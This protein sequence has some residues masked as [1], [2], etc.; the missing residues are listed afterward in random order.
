M[1]DQRSCARVCHRAEDAVLIDDITWAPLQ[2]VGCNPSGLV[3]N[4]EGC[5]VYSRATDRHG[6]RVERAGPEWYRLRVSL[7]HVDVVK[8]NSKHTGRNLGETGGMTLA[9]A[10][11]AA[12]RGRPPVAMADHAGAFVAGSPEANCTQCH[13][14][15]GTGALRKSRE[16]DTEMTAL[17]AQTRLLRAQL[18]IACQL[19]GCVHVGGVIARIKRQPGR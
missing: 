1:R 17:S 15:S 5:L 10:L 9:S 11:R 14:R 19:Q 3:H 6:S 7:H 12:E 8:H 16:A 18:L 2:L 4:L 13:R